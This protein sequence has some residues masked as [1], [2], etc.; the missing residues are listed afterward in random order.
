MFKAAQRIGQRSTC[1]KSRGRAL[2]QAE[3]KFDIAFLVAARSRERLRVLDLRGRNSS[4]AGRR[5]QHE[6]RAQYGKP[7]LDR[8]LPTNRSLRRVKIG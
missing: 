6:R 3:V 8:A 5:P 2:D 1:T 4:S 7:V